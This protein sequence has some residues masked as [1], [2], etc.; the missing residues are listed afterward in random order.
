[1]AIAAAEITPGQPLTASVWQRP[2]IA[3]ATREA[4]AWRQAGAGLALLKLEHTEPVWPLL[5]HSEYPETRSRL[6]LR[7]GPAGVPGRILLER[8]KREKDVSRRRALI[9]ALGEYTEKDL[10][11]AERWPLVEKLLKWY[12]DD[13]DPGIHGAIDWLLRHGKDG[14]EDRPLD[15]KQAKALA[16]IDADLAEQAR[17]RRAA[18]LAGRVTVPASGGLTVLAATAPD[19]A[20][21]IDKG[22]GWYVNGQ[23]QTLTIIDSREPFLMGS[24]GHET[25]RS[26]DETLHWRQIGRRYAIGTK[27]VTVAQFERFRKAHS[28]NQEHSPAPNCPVIAVT[29]YEAAA[30]CNWLS[31]QEG[32]PKEQWCY[33]DKISEG[34]KPYP[35]YLKRKGYRLP[36]GPEWEFACRAGARTSRY[37]GSAVDLLPRYAWYLANSPDRTWPVGQKRPNDLGLFDMQGNV[38]SWCQEGGRVYPDYPSGSPERPVRDVEDVREVVDKWGRVLRGAS[39]VNRPSGVR[40]PYREL[41]RPTVRTSAVGLRVARTCD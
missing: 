21:L 18:A 29:W 4:L 8:L 31:E 25:S 22:R 10:S 16:K 28:V 32:I 30:Y 19:G 39:F 38:W 24:P 3:E 15:W 14:K 33:P 20:G 9:V 40:A 27:P 12:R 36:T 35:D 34:M 5:K 23:G 41:A 37:Y 2:V 11:E 13:P 7:L 26:T 17:A 6:L 1:V